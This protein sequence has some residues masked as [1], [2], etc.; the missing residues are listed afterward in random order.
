MTAAKTVL[1]TL[2]RSGEVRRGLGQGVA[3]AWPW[4]AGSVAVP[5]DGCHVGRR[6]EGMGIGDSLR[7]DLGLRAEQE[8]VWFAS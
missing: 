6:R 8:V 7:A 5:K 1:G 2:E 4:R 3:R